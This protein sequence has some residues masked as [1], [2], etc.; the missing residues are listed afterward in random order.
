M[1]IVFCIMKTLIQ[2]FVL[3][4]CL[5]SI[6]CAFT[7]DYKYSLLTKGWFKLNVVP[8]TWHDARLRCSLQG[9]VLA[10]PTSSAMAA[11]MRHTMK[12]FFIQDTEVFT[13]IHAT[14]S[15]GSYYT[16]DGIPLSKIPLVWANNEP[17]NFGNKE[18]CIT[19]SSNGSAADRYCEEPR[20]Y[21]CFRSGE[22]EVLT[23]R[24]GTVDDTDDGY[25]YYEV[26]EKCYK[27]HR[28]PGTFDR[29][30]FV[31]SAENGHL[32]IINNE[33]EAE[34]L[35]QVFAD[36]PAAWIPGIF[37]KDVAFIGF[38]DWGLWGDWRTIHGETLKEAGYDK[39]SGGEPN[40]ATTG[41]H[42][43]AIYRSALLDDL[44]CD[45]PA[46]FICEKDPAYPPICQ[47][48]ADEEIDIDERFNN[49]VE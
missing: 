24:C 35:R 40:N 2:C 48:T 29:A 28:V 14:F 45:K 23:N 6:E 43:G 21:I 4:F 26:T 38:H 42:C 46:P 34:V 16:V 44:W 39:F 1:Y 27:F 47:P 37:W 30:H 32:A 19:F 49:N 17:D 9:A 31:C 10:S 8:E 15:S 36:N 25:Y 33:D 22:K 7:C 20:P 11:E 3:I 41:E 5:Y 18:R 12:N 13:G